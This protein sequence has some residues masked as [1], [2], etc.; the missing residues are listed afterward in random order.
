LK[1]N[2]VCF[3]RPAKKKENTQEAH[4]YGEVFGGIVDFVVF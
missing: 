3:D 2:K 1:I 4:G